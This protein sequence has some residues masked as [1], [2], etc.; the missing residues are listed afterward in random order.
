MDRLNERIEVARKAL[1]SFRG[2]LREPASPMN[3]AMREIAG[4]AGS[5]SG[6]DRSG[7]EADLATALSP[8]DSGARGG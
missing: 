4:S 2:A 3:A 6:N 5:R 1:T 7:P 8:P